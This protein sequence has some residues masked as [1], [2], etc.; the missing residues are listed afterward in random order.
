[1]DEVQEATVVR[2]QV[3]PVECLP[4]VET[5]AESLREVSPAGRHAGW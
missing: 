2:R 3:E 5:V 1:M 4:A